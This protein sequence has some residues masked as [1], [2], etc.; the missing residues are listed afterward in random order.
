MHSVFS[1]F[2]PQARAIAHLWWWMFG[3]GVTIWLAVTLTALYAARARRGERSPNTLNEITPVVHRRVERV[4]ASAV[5]VTFLI[6]AAFLAYDFTAGRA[7]A[8][9]PKVALTINVTGHQWW[10]DAVYE[11]PDPSKQVQTANE[12]HVPVGETVQLTLR[13]ADVIHSFW[14]PN[15][16]GKKDLIPGYTTALFFRADTAGVYRGQCAEFCGLQHAKMAFYIV[17]EPRPKF[18]AWLAAASTPS[19]PPTDPTLV[20]GKQVFMSS[21]CPLCHSISGTDARATVGPGLS[22]FKSR[23]S[24]ASGTLANTRENLTRW[25][26][27]PSAFKP[28]VRMPA[29]PLKPAELDALVSYLETLK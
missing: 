7:L 27:N 21:G 24:I 16:N 18:A 1:P 29:L 20:Y 22:H 9:H 13:A 26:Q 5:F 17:A 6:L 23:A 15:L 12:I 19:P 3:V 8:A 4:I 11:D 14:V 2:S 28:G 25:I 10:W